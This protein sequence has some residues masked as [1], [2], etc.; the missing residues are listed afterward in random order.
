MEWHSICNCHPTS[1]KAE[2]KVTESICLFIIINLA[3]A[4]FQIKTIKKYFGIVNIPVLKSG[5]TKNVGDIQTNRSDR[6]RKKLLAFLLKIL[7]M[8]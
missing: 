7:S 8:L 5:D 4:D 2:K 3:N 1:A 6:F